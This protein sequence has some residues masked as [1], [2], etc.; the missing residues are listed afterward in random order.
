[1]RLYFAYGNNLDSEKMLNRCSGEAKGKS[2]AVLLKYRFLINTDGVATVKKDTTTNVE[3][4]VWEI[5]AEC[6]RKLDVCEGVKSGIYIKKDLLVELDGY[7][8]ATALVYI[9]NNEM[10]GGKSKENGKYLERIISNARRL[11]F[12]DNYISHLESLRV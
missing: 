8:Q 10:A 9:A 5:T 4:Y 12:S 1:M 2:N 11:S 3:G 6:E 7:I